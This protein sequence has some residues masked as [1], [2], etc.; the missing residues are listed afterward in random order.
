MTRHNFAHKRS[1]AEL[2]QNSSE[3]GAEVRGML[4]TRSDDGGGPM[5]HMGPNWEFAGNSD[6][7]PMNHHH[8]AHKRRG[9]VSILS[10]ARRQGSESELRYPVDKVCAVTRRHAGRGRDRIMVGDGLS[11]KG[12]RN[13]LVSFCELPVPC[14]L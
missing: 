5:S 2:T 12:K 9:H 11:P 1:P 10:L 4:L 3:H 14:K 6:C 7:S 8:F 13:S